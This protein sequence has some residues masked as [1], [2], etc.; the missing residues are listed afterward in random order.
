MSVCV[1]VWKV[2]GIVGRGDVEELG[3]FECVCF[4]K[5]GRMKGGGM[6]GGR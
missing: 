1:C 6:G 5:N 3:N 2:G 4:R